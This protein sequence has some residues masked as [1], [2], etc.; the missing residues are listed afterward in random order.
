MKK[1]PH[2]LSNP[3]LSGRH[4]AKP[5]QS[6]A[7]RRH[8]HSDH[9]H[10][11]F[12]L[13]RLAQAR[14]VPR[15]RRRTYTALE[16]TSVDAEFIQIALRI[17]CRRPHTRIRTKLQTSDRCAMRI[18]IRLVASSLPFDPAGF[19]HDGSRRI[20]SKTQD[21]TS[22]EGQVQQAACFESLE[23][24]GD[25]TNQCGW[26]ASLAGGRQLSAR[27]TNWKPA[28]LMNRWKPSQQKLVPKN[29]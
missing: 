26:T 10:I 18:S 22:A 16:R 14:Q 1:P 23:T 29:K 25:P 4:R 17:A 11:F 13:P 21:C 7:Q 6:W 24:H 19:S 5:L 3:A 2:V 8:T 28:L 9:T 20:C 12:S 27:A 15:S